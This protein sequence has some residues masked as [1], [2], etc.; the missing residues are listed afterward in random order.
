MKTD[1]TCKLMNLK[2][3]D[4]KTFRFRNVKA[5]KLPLNSSSISLFPLLP[6]HLEIDGTE[7]LKGINKDLKAIRGLTLLF[8]RKS[9][10][11]WS[12]DVKMSIRVGSPDYS[13]VS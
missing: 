11:S 6:L 13:Y 2:F 5:V 4:I 8:G 1:F 10:L 9:E 3:H 12:T 7:D